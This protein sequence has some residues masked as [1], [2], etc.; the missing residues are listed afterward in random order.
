MCGKSAETGEVKRVRG[1]GAVDIGG[2]KGEGG[3]DEG[4]Q[5]RKEGEGRVE[6]ERE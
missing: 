6:R 5:K 2:G 4:G 3:V 1:S